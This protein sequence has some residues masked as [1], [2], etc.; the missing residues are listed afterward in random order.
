MSELGKLAGKGEERLHN[1]QNV[2]A[3]AFLSGIERPE[4]RLKYYGTD[5]A[6]LAILNLEGLGGLD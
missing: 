6:N 3:F 1:I 5:P 4:E 2:Y